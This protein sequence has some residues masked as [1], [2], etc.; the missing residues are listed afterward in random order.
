MTTSSSIGRR[1]ITEALRKAAAFYFFRYGFG[2]TFEIGVMPWG[3]RRADLVANKVNGS[4][5]VVEVKSCLADFRSDSKWRY[6]LEY[7]DKFVF[8]T[9]QS[10]FAKIRDNLPDEVG[11]LCLDEK[12]GWA[13]MAKRCPILPLTDERRIQ[14]L[15]RLAYRQAELS[16]RTQRARQRVFL[17]GKVHD[18]SDLMPKASRRRR[19][20]K[21]ARRRIK[22]TARQRTV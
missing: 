20:T 10:V 7:C 17:D 8:M 2:V 3:S 1:A 4:I 5:V 9:T 21:K 15:A 22:K 6:Y 11:V 12:T 14:V 18:I 16:K 19:P 13:Y